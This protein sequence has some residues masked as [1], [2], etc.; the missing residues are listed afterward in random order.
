[1]PFRG[2]GGTVVHKRNLHMLCRNAQDLMDALVE[3]DPG[4]RD[5]PDD[6]CIVALMQVRPAFAY[7]HLRMLEEEER[8]QYHHWVATCGVNPAELWFSLTCSR[9]AKPITKFRYVSIWHAPR[10]K[11]G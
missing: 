3:E 8:M 5:M 2:T 11:L 1:M 9:S 7:D 6:Y 4:A 10:V